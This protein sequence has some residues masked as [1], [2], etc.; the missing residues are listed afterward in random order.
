MFKLHSSGWI[1]KPLPPHYSVHWELADGRSTDARFDTLALAEK[2][3][4]LLKSNTPPIPCTLVTIHRSKRIGRT[5]IIRST[6]ITPGTSRSLAHVVAYRVELWYRTVDERVSF[7]IYRCP[8]GHWGVWHSPMSRLADWEEVK[9]SFTEKQHA[10][11]WL[12]QLFH[13]NGY[14]VVEKA[15]TEAAR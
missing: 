15:T 6:T 1:K 2:L 5:P 8:D 9:S 3:R 10:E 13:D 12:E 14:S 11:A 7:R 4:D